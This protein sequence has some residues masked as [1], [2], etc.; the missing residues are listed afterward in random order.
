MHAGALGPRGQRIW[1]LAGTGEGPPLASALLERGWQV[2]VSVV[3]AAAGRAYPAAAGLEL[4]VGAIGDAAAVAQALEQ[5]ALA[6][7]S[8]SWVVDATHPFASRISADLAEACRLHRQPLLRLHRPQLPAGR[9]ILLPQLADLQTLPLAG[10]R[11]LLAIGARQL[12]RVVGLSATACHH[13]RI[14]PNATALAQAMAAGLA[15][16]RLACLRPSLEGQIEAAL[17]RRWRI[18]VVLCRR[19]GGCGE[20]LWHQL[21]ADL[22]L[23]LLLLDRPAEPAA[24]ECLAWQQLLDRLGAPEWQLPGGKA[25]GGNR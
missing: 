15:A 1:I 8:P 17:C 22:D 16:D 12:A 19:S 6:G 14:L 2:R 11:L 10:R 23:Q 4:A 3:S 24:V 13:A 9:A 18:E 25:D 7:T 5:F 21:A 20:Q